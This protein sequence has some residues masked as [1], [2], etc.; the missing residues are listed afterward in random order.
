MFSTSL[1]MCPQFDF[2]SNADSQ[3]NPSP[4]YFGYTR[5]WCLSIVP[6]YVIYCSVNNNTNL[7]SGTHPTDRKYYVQTLANELYLYNESV[8]KIHLLC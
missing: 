8:C 2:G 6:N 1:E 5:S 4:I 7:A 3:V